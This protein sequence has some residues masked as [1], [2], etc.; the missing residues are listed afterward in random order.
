MA[1]SFLN[2]GCHSETT[3][4]IFSWDT[5]D[6]NLT[7]SF[8]PFMEISLKLLFSSTMHCQQATLAKCTQ[9]SS[10]KL[11]LNVYLIDSA[12]ENVGCYCC[13]GKDEWLSVHT[14]YILKTVPIQHVSPHSQTT[15]AGVTSD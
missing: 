15:P 9:I 3:F 4:K 10:F 11:C 7:T 8:C 14:A 2:S 1:Q 12:I 6:M 5:A 13:N